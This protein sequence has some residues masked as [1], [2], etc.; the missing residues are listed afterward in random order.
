VEQKTDSV[1]ARSGASSEVLRARWHAPSDRR[2]SCTV[3]ENRANDPLGS[4]VDS[5]S[6][7]QGYGSAYDFAGLGKQAAAVSILATAYFLAAAVGAHIVNT[8]CNVFSDYISDYAVGPLGWI[9]GS[10]FLASCLGCLALAIS[11]ALVVPPEALSKTGAVLL[12]VVGVS[13]AIDFAFPTDILPPGAPPTTTVGAIHLVDA[14]FGWVLFTIGAILISTRLR[15]DAY[16]KTWQPILTTLAWLSVLLLVVLI[17]VVVSKVPIG[18]LAEK[19][20]ILDRNI[21]GLM[22]AILIFTAPRKLI[23]QAR[24]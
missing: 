11:V 2:E 23:S 22:L 15:R 16:W 18:G 3:L 10:A 20:F 19:A 24:R 12:A 14:L 8:Q 6:R 9:Y 13:F 7:R 5:H 17:V 4:I 21:W 1:E